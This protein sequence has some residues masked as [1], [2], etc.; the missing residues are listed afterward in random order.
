MSFWS[1]SG[2]GF[3][4]R[5]GGDVLTDVNLEI[6]PGENAALIGPN[7]SGKTTLGKLMVGVLKPTAG[8]VILHGRGISEWS[9]PEVGRQVGY[10]F[11]NPER[12]LFTGSVLDEVSFGLKHSGT[13]PET[14]RGKSLE[15]LEYMGLDHALERFPFNLSRGEKQRLAM[16]AVMV[17]QPGFLLLDEPTTGLDRAHRKAFCALLSRVFESGTGWILITHDEELLD[18]ARPARILRVEEGRVAG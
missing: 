4:Y 6:A 3:R 13:D 10:L 2:V 11:Q 15:M 9:L 14:A 17:L 8:S 12:Q 18:M 7:G 5:E 1:L 16:A